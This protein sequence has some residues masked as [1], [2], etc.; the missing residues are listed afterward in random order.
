[1]WLRESQINDM[2]V[3]ALLTE[4]NHASLYLMREQDR[5]HC[6]LYDLTKAN[7]QPKTKPLPTDI[8]L[9]SWTHIAIQ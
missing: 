2:L 1:M 7:S 6:Q 9:T 3:L 4:V 5:L 8:N